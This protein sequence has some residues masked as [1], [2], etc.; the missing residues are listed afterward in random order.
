MREDEGVV[1][2]LGC[3][4][5][6]DALIGGGRGGQNGG[7]GGQVVE[8]SPQPA[9][10]GAEV[11]PPIRDAMGFIAHERERSSLHRVEDTTTEAGIGQAF[12]CDQEEVDGV[13]G[14]PGLDGVPCVE[15]GRVDGLGDES[16]ASGCLDLIAHEGQQGRDHDRG[17]PTSIPQHSGCGE[18]D[19]RLAEPGAGDE[20][21]SLST[22]NDS[23]DGGQ[24]LGP[25][26][27]SLTGQRLD[28]V[29]E[30]ACDL[31][32]GGSGRFGDHGTCLPLAL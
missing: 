2:Q 21:G 15:V 3:D 17:A 30:L 28:V 5:V 23:I 24:L 25:G 4:V 12:R 16:E 13:L 31:G 8:E 27:G 1:T 9:V 18:V 10:I 26:G 20:E 29:V 11:V 32:R 22:G 7:P 6:G 14:D 19:R